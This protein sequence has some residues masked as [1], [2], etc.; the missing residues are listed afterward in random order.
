[1]V[2]HGGK[3]WQ[4]EL[5]QYLLAFDGDPGE[6]SPSIIER[7][8]V[9]PS[10]EDWFDQ[11]VAL[12]QQDSEAAIRAYERAIA[13]DPTHVDAQIN[14]GR[15]VHE[16][17]HLARAERVYRDALDAGGSDAVLLFNPGALFDDLGCKPDAA[18]AYAAAWDVDPDF[19]DCHHSLALLF[20]QLE[21]PKEAIKHMSKY[22]RLIET[23]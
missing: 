4:A 19:A 5:G 6:G 21:K 3:H 16:E 23:S 14:M 18:A 10:N 9:P 11:A 13:A 20:E 22:R 8:E 12:K 15:L 2:S 1:M 17:R 7:I